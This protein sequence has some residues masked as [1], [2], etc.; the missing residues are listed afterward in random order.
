MN[1]LIQSPRFVDQ[2]N[3]W[4]LTLQQISLGFDRKKNTQLQCALVYLFQEE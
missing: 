3:I 2:S 1:N 4:A